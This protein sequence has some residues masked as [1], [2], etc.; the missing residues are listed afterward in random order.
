[1]A[2]PVCSLLY[3]R[4]GKEKSKETVCHLPQQ[5][6]CYVTV[7]G[8]CQLVKLFQKVRQGNGE[9]SHR[10]G[11][12]D[13]SGFEIHRK[14]ATGSF[15]CVLRQRIPKI[16]D[17]AKYV[18]QYVF[19]ISLF[20]PIFFIIF[21]FNCT[22]ILKGREATASLPY[23]KAYLSTLVSCHLVSLKEHVALEKFN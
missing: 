9:S 21:L 2:S 10:K 3:Y 8:Q 7:H 23:F 22:Y 20:I 11:S 13:V 1:M 6:T 4:A 5:E 17:F 15:F 18:S 19:Y 12:A 14:P 16:S